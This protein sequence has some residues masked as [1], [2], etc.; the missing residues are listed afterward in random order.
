MNNQDR[1]SKVIKT[2]KANKPVLSDKE[3]LTDDIMGRIQGSVG[4]TTFYEKLG[5]YLFGWADHSW[6]RGTMAAAAVLFIGIFITQQII[7]TN[8]ITNLEKQLIRTVNTI[9]NH[10]PDLGIMQKVLLNIVAK[11]Q[12]MKDSIT[13]SISDLDELL[14]SYMELQQNYEDLQKSFGLEP[15]IQDMIR[16]SMEE[17]TDDDKLKLN[18]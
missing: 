14:K 9:N 4:K 15:Y 6:I 7:I 17:N 10:E 12:M 1:Y 13:L 3:K 18:L 2:L 16:R 11:D 8:R 5:N